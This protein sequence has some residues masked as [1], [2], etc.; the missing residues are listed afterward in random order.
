MTSH[1]H[2]GDSTAHSDLKNEKRPLSTLAQRPRFPVVHGFFLQSLP[3]GGAG[4]I[5]TGDGGFAIREMVD[6]NAIDVGYVRK[7]PVVMESLNT[8]GLPEFTLLAAQL[9]N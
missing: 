3:Q 2:D 6:A 1:H 5:R 4:R 9:F 7:T 8:D